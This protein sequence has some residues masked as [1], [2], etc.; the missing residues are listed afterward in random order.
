VSGRTTATFALDQR[1]DRWALPDGS[2]QR[3]RSGLGYRPVTL[4]L[5]PERNGV[6]LTLAFDMP[7]EGSPAVNRYQAT[8]FDLDHPLLQREL[9]VDVRPGASASARLGTVK[10]HTPGGHLFLLEELG[11]PALT[12]VRATLTVRE[13]VERPLMPLMWAGIGMLLAGIGWTTYRLVLRA[14]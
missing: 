11:T 9:S 6:R 3:F 8:L 1:A 4:D 12:P 10:I 14:T 7:A 2:I 5:H 13:E